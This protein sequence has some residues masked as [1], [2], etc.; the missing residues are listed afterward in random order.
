MGERDGAGWDVKILLSGPL[1]AERQVRGHPSIS[2]QPSQ[3]EGSSP[4]PTSLAPQA[5]KD[6]ITTFPVLAARTWVQVTGLWEDQGPMSQGHPG[7]RG[8]LSW[9]NRPAWH[10]GAE[11]AEGGSW[12]AQGVSV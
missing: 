5:E 11:E 4:S 12:G 1:R 9:P 3:G 6:K 8:Q 10:L 7:A 2:A